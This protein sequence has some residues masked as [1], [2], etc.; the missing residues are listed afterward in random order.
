MQ[1]VEASTLA[2]QRTPLTAQIASIL[3]ESSVSP[4]NFF[5]NI[6]IVPNSPSL[7]GAAVSA[8]VY[9]S[10]SEVNFDTVL[11]IAPSGIGEFKRITVCGLDS[12]GTPLGEVEVDDRVRNEL[13][14][15]DDDIYLD[16]TGHFNMTGVDVQLPFLQTV[17]GE[18]KIVPLVMGSESV[19]FCKELGSAVGEIMFNRNTLTVACVDILSATPRGLK[20][21]KQALEDLDVPRMMTLLNQENEIVVQ[22]KGGILAAMMAA[23]HRRSDRVHISHLSAPEGD[24]HGFVGALIGRG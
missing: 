14:D 2:T 12:Y 5:A 1:Q 24:A 13:C 9:S 23:T 7:D 21:F 6:V 4:V 17:L 11:S 8:Q 22:G 20:L 18:F 15:E 3:K 10:L 16:D 19:D